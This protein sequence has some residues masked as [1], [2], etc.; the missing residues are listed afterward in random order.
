MWNYFTLAILSTIN[1]GYYLGSLA[2]LHEISM[3]NDSLDNFIFTISMLGVVVSMMCILNACKCF[4]QTVSCM[5]L[6]EV[7]INSILLSSFI[8]LSIQGLITVLL[9]N[10]YECEHSY[11]SV[12]NK[13]NKCFAWIELYY[14]IPS[15]GI[16]F[17]IQIIL[18]LCLLKKRKRMMSYNAIQE[19]KK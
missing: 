14:T 17:I 11:P 12:E 18:Q 1:I 19:V 9:T 4:N 16:L 7:L 15:F 5:F 2:L 8:V 6:L 10:E 3:G 13:Y